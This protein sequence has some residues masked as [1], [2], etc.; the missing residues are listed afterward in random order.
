MEA[1]HCGE[2]VVHDGLERRVFGGDGWRVWLGC[3]D[4]VIMEVDLD[5]KLWKEVRYEGSYGRWG[6]TLLV[7]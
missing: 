4:V 1:G 5:G 2:W 6:T 3:L 7:T